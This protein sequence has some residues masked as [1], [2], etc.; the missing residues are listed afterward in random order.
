MTLETRTSIGWADQARQ[1]SDAR[2]VQEIQDLKQRVADLKASLCYLSESLELEVEESEKLRVKNDRLKTS[3]EQAAKD[4]ASSALNKVTK[5]PPPLEEFLQNK[6]SSTKSYSDIID[7]K[8]FDK[9]WEQVSTS[10]DKKLKIYFAI[11][12]AEKNNIEM[13]S[14]LDLEG[15]DFASYYM[16]HN[17]VFVDGITG[18]E[19]IPDHVEPEAICAFRSLFEAASMHDAHEVLLYLYSLLDDVRY[20][21]SYSKYDALDIIF[22]AYDMDDNI[23]AYN[24]FYDIDGAVLVDVL[25]EIKKGDQENDGNLFNQVTKSLFKSA[26]INGDSEYLQS[27]YEYIS[28]DDCDFSQ[29]D[30]LKIIIKYFAQDEGGLPAFFVGLPIDILDKMLDVL[31]SKDSH[32]QMLDVLL[33]HYEA[34]SDAAGHMFSI[35]FYMHYGKKDDGNE[36]GFESEC[37]SSRSSSFSGDKDFYDTPE[38]ESSLLVLGEPVGEGEEWL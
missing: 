22:D 17:F 13:L 18:S 30:A 27:L 3:L 5:K 28:E 31:T 19:Y 12:A 32:D 38:A 16:Q 33:D 15:I 4:L 34:N 29:Y 8:G 21:D 35:D 14:L 6:Y 20:Q 7:E 9:V 23:K 10:K 24:F 26:S 1:A 36:S 11:A 37:D 25:E 2:S